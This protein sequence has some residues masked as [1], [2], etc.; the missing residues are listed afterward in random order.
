VAA[1]EWLAIDME[2]LYGLCVEVVDDRKPKL[3]DGVIRVALFRAIRELLINVARHAGVHRARVSILEERDGARVEVVDEG[4][5]MGAGLAE[6]GLGLALARERLRNLGGGLRI[7]ST[8]GKG[9]RAVAQVPLQ[10][11]HDAE[12]TL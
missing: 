4:V 3:L 2:R 8:P 12:M 1:I 10:S 5:G 11:E 9:T 6:R 7:E